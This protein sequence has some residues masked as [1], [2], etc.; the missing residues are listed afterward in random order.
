MFY[1]DK[2]TKSE[3]IYFLP[4]T[5]L[6]FQKA[7]GNYIDWTEAG[8]EDFKNLEAASKRKPDLTRCH[9][10]SVLSFVMR[11]KVLVYG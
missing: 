2:R 5:L 3:T 7:E 10:N 4:E 8:V 11:I 9:S 6:G 1:I